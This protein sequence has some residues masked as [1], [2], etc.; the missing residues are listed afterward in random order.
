MIFYRF[1]KTKTL[2]KIKNSY[3]VLLLHHLNQHQNTKRG[4]H[5]VVDWLFHRS[6][7]MNVVIRNI[8]KQLY[9]QILESKI[10]K[11]N[12][13]TIIYI[14]TYICIGDVYVYITDSDM[15]KTACNTK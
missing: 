8:T 5:A 1:G 13:I 12:F 6:I 15:I 10:F 14:C 2:R 4:P 11:K 7:E 3:G 9:D